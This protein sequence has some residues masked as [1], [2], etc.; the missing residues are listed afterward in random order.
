[1]TTLLF[2]PA[3][4]GSTEIIGKNFKKLNGLPLIHYTL[5]LCKKFS[6]KFSLFVST[7]SLKIKRYAKK[8]GFKENYLR[9]KKLSTS[10]S[11]VVD[12]IIHGVEWLK[13]NNVKIEDIILLQPTS[14]LR[15]YRDLSKAYQLYKK[16]K[17]KSLVSV[18]KVSE[19]SLGHIKILKKKKW[20]FL[21]KRKTRVFRRQ[22]YPNNHYI[23]NGAFYIFNY[24]YLK[25]NKTVVKENQTYLYETVRLSSIDIDSK[26]DFQLAELIIKNK[27]LL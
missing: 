19:N 15:K 17:L 26:S 12:S 18:S 20:K 14:P 2:I 8:F 23:V 22:D 24:E 7:D 21:Y 4:K 27:K 11:N 25:K 3:R 1:M 13:N 5:K 10:K 16:K 9:P 6:K